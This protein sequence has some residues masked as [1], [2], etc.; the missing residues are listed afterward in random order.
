MEKYGHVLILCSFFL[1]WIVESF[2]RFFGLI[3][4]LF[5]FV[6]FIK[7]RIRRTNLL[8]Y[9]Y[10]FPFFPT[11][12]SYRFKKDYKVNHIRGIRTIIKK[13]YQTRCRSRPTYVSYLHRLTRPFLSIPFACN[14][15]S[16]AVKIPLF[17]AYRH[18]NFP[19]RLTER[20]TVVQN[21]R[22]GASIKWVSTNRHDR[23]T[24]RSC[25]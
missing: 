22:E 23:L 4:F 18:V 8:N 19:R 3:L 1:R 6:T 10:H 11:N 24:Y 7:D 25:E 16:H 2:T 13:T 14:C 21:E 5:S 12:F 15:N 20:V 17:L 9:N